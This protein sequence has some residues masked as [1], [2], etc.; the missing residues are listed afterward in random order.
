MS[1]SEKAY[2]I[3]KQICRSILDA[4]PDSEV[5]RAARIMAILE[6]EF[7][8][9]TEQRLEELAETGR[10]EAAASL[11]GED[12]A[13]ST[14]EI[15]HPF[16]AEVILAIERGRSRDLVGPDF[17]RRASQL[18][19]PSPQQ[20]VASSEAR[21]AIFNDL[22][23]YFRNVDRMDALLQGAAEAA[24]EKNLRKTE[25]GKLVVIPLRRAWLGV[26][27]YVRPEHLL[28]EDGQDKHIAIGT[29]VVVNRRTDAGRGVVIEGK[30]SEAAKRA[31]GTKA[32]YGVRLD[33][34]F[35]QVP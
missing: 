11:A 32:A 4:L 9:R 23:R 5:R 27:V 3:Y 7:V 17:S 26:K 1:Q 35:E 24:P 30:G 25:F 28:R 15:K 19:Q 6:A 8:S 34:K 18:N 16:S 22:M 2:T 21:K 13:L 33:P 10:G 20:L 31:V 29:R 12:S 14:L